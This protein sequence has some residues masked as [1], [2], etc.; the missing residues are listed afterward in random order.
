[1]VDRIEREL[2][3]PAPPEEVWE[4]IIAPGWL[5]DEVGMDLVPGGSAVFR[6]NGSV[7]DGWVEEV[8]APGPPGSD[9]RLAFWWHAGDEVATRVELTLERDGDGGTRLRVTEER[10]LELLDLVGIPLPG[11]S[12]TTHGPALLAAA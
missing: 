11:S 8:V 4:L 12:G 1:M 7:K 3:L 10:P 5:A 9:A 6:S 2:H